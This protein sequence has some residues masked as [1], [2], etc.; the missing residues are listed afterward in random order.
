M[1][2][3]I[4]DQI[5]LYIHCYAHTLNL[6]LADSAAI[7]V[8]VVTLFAN[9]KTL[10]VLFSIGLRKSITY[11]NQHSCLMAFRFA[12]LKESTLLSARECKGD[13]FADIFGML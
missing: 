1:Q 4:K 9:L 10:Y 12:L 13:V 3:L 2:A 11:S 7:A 8:D 5:N 6:V